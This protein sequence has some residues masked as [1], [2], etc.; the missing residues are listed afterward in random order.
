MP[1]CSE[2]VLDALT[3]W[4]DL[5]HAVE[6]SLAPTVV[7]PLYRARAVTAFSADSVDDVRNAVVANRLPKRGTV[8]LR[9]AL[10]IE[11]AL[12]AACAEDD[13]F[14]AKVLPAYR[15]HLHNLVPIFQSNRHHILSRMR[16]D[17]IPTAEDADLIRG[18]LLE[19]V[20]QQMDSHE[21]LF[22]SMLQEK[23]EDMAEDTADNGLL[24]CKMCKSS[25]VVWD[26]IQTRSADE[27]M[28]IYA[29]CLKCQHKWRMS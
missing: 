2:A 9:T 15:E 28:S 27:G 21:K 16:P 7:I 10:Q 6:P 19:R 5:W 3:E 24:Q 12:F 8:P 17:Q 18:S 29:M 1:A 11:C 23:F 14:A 20:Q 4:R 13:P 26:Q 25:N 22:R